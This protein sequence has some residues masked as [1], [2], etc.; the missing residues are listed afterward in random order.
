LGFLQGK[1]NCGTNNERRRA[2][3]REARWPSG[4]KMQAGPW[5]ASTPG[6]GTRSVS[7]LASNPYCWNATT[8]F[9]QRACALRASDCMCKEEEECAHTVRI[10]SPQSQM[11]FSNEEQLS[12]IQARIEN[13]KNGN[14]PSSFSCDPSLPHTFTARQSLLSSYWNPPLHPADSHRVRIRRR[15]S[16][17]LRAP[18]PCPRRHNQRPRGQG[19]LENLEIPL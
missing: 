15:V 13:I 12:Q 16:R 4:N 9:S 19:N 6:E 2:D 1:L 18:L 10:P 3:R 7:R 14:P 8:C 17:G 11:S 5:S